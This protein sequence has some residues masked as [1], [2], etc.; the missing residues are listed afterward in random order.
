MPSDHPAF[1]EIARAERL[2][3]KVAHALT[4]SILAGRLTVGDKLPSERELSEQFAVSRPVVREA[5]RGLKARGLLVDHPRRGHVVAAVDADVVSRSLT[6][7]V[8]GRR[9]DYAPLLEVR[10]VLE[11]SAAGIAAERATD[12][13]LETLAAAEAK[14]TPGLGA[15]AAAVADVEFHRAIAAT[16]AN[17]YFVL[18]ID[19]L[20][21]VLLDAQRPTLADP[22]IVG[23]ARRAHRRILGAIRAHDAQ[24]ARE[25]MQAHLDLAGRQVAALV[26]ST[27]P[28]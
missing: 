11:V 9:V 12:E 18:L 10:A 4:E 7:Y 27:R 8:R 13:Q 19:S 24:A 17:E 26:R 25:A 2:S 5:V 14:L 3:D 15:D 28:G 20:R 22:K 1:E 21:E 23:T 16:T 6:L